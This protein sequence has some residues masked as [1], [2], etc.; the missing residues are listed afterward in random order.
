LDKDDPV[1]RLEPRAMVVHHTDP[2]GLSGCLP[3]EI[4]EASRYDV[5]DASTGVTAC[6]ANQ[7]LKAVG[8]EGDPDRRYKG[9]KRKQTATSPPRVPAA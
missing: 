3:A 4:D 9:Q 8:G 1:G 6:D 2:D 7:E 5:L